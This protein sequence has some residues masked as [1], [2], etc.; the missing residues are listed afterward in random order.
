MYLQPQFPD[1][2]KPK[3]PLEVGR[4]LAVLI[5]TS[6]QVMMTILWVLI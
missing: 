5:E 3:H 6:C 1:R 2:E 4:D